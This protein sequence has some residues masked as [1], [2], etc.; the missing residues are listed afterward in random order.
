MIS[1]GEMPWRFNSQL[2]RKAMLTIKME[3]SRMLYSTD[4]AVFCHLCRTPH[5]NQSAKIKEVLGTMIIRHIYFD[6][7]FPNDQMDLVVRCC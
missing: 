7:F 3:A 5:R 6:F 4:G 2:I 1:N